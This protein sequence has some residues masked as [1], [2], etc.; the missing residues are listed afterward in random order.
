MKAESHYKPIITS[1]RAI[2]ALMVCFYHFSFFQLVDGSYSLFSD[3]D[4]ILEIA[5]LGKYGVHVFFLISGFIIPYVLYLNMY[6]IKTFGKFLAK[7][8]IRLEIP[9]WAV[10]AATFAVWG[11]YS[12]KGDIAALPRDIT[13]VNLISHLF[14]LNEFLDELWYNDIFWTLAIEFQLYLFIGLIFPFIFNKSQRVFSGFIAAMMLLG[15]YGDLFTSFEGSSI[16]THYIWIFNLGF[17]LVYRLKMSMSDLLF[18]GLITGNIAL[19]YLDAR[20]SYEM[21]HLLVI[22]S[23]AI[24]LI[25]NNN[26]VMDFLGKISY[27]LYLSHGLTGMQFLYLTRDLEWNPYLKLVLAFIIGILGAAVMYFLIE[28]PAINLS[29]RIRYKD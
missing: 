1:L 13:A 19:I 2:A 22:G 18:Y 28:K 21:G 3:G 25:E 11:L 27:S 29:K 6:E 12:I 20:F 17:V 15:F 9:Y 14:Y 23:S 7:R 24:L 26:K 5:R 4:G 8:F 10:I 16:F